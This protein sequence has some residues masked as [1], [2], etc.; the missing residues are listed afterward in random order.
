MIHA[1]VAAVTRRIVERSQPG[2]RAYLDLIDREREN[3]VRR[4]NLGCANLAHAYAG[5]DEDREAMKADRGM[6]I[7]LVTAYN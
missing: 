2:R 6:N 7:G 4:P 3:A 5:T 1:A